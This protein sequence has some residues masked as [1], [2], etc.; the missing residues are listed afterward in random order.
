MIFIIYVHS[1]NRSLLPI[2]LKVCTLI[3]SYHIA[4][5]VSFKWEDGNVF[6]SIMFLA[7]LFEVTGDDESLAS[8][9]E[10]PASE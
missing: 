9:I 4:F 2:N 3:I 10:V 1:L 5:K 8:V 7:I 6:S